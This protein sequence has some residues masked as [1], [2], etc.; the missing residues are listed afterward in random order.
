MVAMLQKNKS[1]IIA[2]PESLALPDSLEKLWL[3]SNVLILE[4]GK[5]VCLKL[6]TNNNPY[7]Y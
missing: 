6:R 5:T 1:K 3:H 4:P 2:E 7:D